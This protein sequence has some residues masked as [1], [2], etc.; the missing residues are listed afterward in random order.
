MISEEEKRMNAAM[1]NAD[2]LLYYAYAVD[3]HSAEDI[4]RV[5]SLCNGDKGLM[6]ACSFLV[7]R[8]GDESLVAVLLTLRAE[9]KEGCANL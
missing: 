1:K 8:A 4:E 7:M 9:R 2:L 5:Y 6:V 3:L